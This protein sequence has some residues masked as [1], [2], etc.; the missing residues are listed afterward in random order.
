VE[1]ERILTEGSKFYKNFA[2]NENPENENMR[3][4]AT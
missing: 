4:I 1:G 2:R 3:S